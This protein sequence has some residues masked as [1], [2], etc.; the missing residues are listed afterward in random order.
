MLESSSDGS[1]LCKGLHK[2]TRGLLH[3]GT[4][5]M[6][7]S[8]DTQSALWAGLLFSRGPV[9]VPVGGSFAENFE[10]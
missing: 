8:R 5:K 2:G 7:F 4:R 10:R 3:G 9:G 6:R 1:S